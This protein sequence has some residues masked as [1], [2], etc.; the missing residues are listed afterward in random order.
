MTIEID[1]TER[2]IVYKVLELSVVKGKDA[3]LFGTLMAKFKPPVTAENPVIPESAFVDHTRIK[4]RDE[5]GNPLVSCKCMGPHK[6][7]AE[8]NDWIQKQNQVPVPGDPVS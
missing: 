7:D 5:K 3:E 8:M 1:E 2:E 4:S 6:D